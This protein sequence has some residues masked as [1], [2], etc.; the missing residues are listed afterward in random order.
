MEM[1]TNSILRS[2]LAFVLTYRLQQEIW[3]ARCC[4]VA[5]MI[6][7]C[8]DR[9]YHESTIVF[10]Q[11]ICTLQ[12]CFRDTMLADDECRWDAKRESYWQ[13]EMFRVLIRFERWSLLMSWEHHTVEGCRLKACRI[14]K[15]CKHCNMYKQTFCV[16]WMNTFINTCLLT[17]MKDLPVLTDVH[18]LSH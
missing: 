9:W 14:E 11:C 5:W 3:V 16:T 2:I 6:P 17:A 4:W 7:C 15:I 1:K 10:C 8:E 13:R 12:F 18:H